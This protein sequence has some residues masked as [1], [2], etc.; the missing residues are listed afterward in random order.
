MPYQPYFIVFITCFVAST[1]IISALYIC[2]YIGSL[3]AISLVSFLEDSLCILLFV[4]QCT[5]LT[6]HLL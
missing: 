4:V 5:F 3:I 1:Y 6:V 2:H